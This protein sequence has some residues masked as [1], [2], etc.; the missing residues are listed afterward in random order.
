MQSVFGSREASAVVVN[1]EIVFSRTCGSCTVCCTQ[2]PIPAQVVSA[3]AKPAGEACLHL[4]R[5]GCG[6][7]QHRPDVCTRF[8]CAWL[9]DGDWPDEWRPDLSGVLCLRETLADGSTGALVTETR[10][11]A[12]LE[13]QGEAILLALLRNTRRVVVAGPDGKRYLMHGAD[14]PLPSAKI[15][16]AP[17]VSVAA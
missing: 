13:P 11:G 1:V 6:I 2:L 4:C 3:A 7:Y 12:L 9:A 17:P 5:S 14:E 16:T 10:P 8:Q 15:E